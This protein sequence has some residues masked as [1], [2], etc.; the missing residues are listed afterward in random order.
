MVRLPIKKRICIFCSSS[1]TLPEI[2]YQKSIEFAKIL[3]NLGYDLVYGG[4]N[5]GIMGKV[6]SEFKNNDREVIGIIPK[7]LSDH[8]PMLYDLKKSIVV[9]NMSK[10]KRLMVRKSFAFIA[11]PGGFGTLEEIFEVITLKQLG[12]IDKP[13]ALLNINHFFD[14]TVEQLDLIYREQF[15]KESNRDLYIITDNVNDI[16][17]YLENYKGV[18]DDSRWVDKL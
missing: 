7:K 16:I 3:S 15:A 12:Y 8:I 14:H 2:Y 17:E 5:L 18:S 10:R 13:I 6:A 11:L 1:D 9:K 4:G